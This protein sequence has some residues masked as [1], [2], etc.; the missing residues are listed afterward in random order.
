MFHHL[1]LKESKKKCPSI[2]SRKS[3]K[4]FVESKLSLIVDRQMLKN[5]KYLIISDMYD[6]INI[7]RTQHEYS[8]ANHQIPIIKVF[9]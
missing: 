9:E 3:I 2:F 8:H 1:K 5:Q 7:D 4:H 6:K